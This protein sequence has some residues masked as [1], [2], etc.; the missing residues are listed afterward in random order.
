[1]TQIPSLWSLANKR[2]VLRQVFAFHLSRYSKEV[3]GLPKG[4]SVV[5]APSVTSVGTT[6]TP[7]NALAWIHRPSEI[8]QSALAQT[9]G[10]R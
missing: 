2:F 4:L 6:T 1:M 8:A 5:V 7:L 10:L 9:F 3:I